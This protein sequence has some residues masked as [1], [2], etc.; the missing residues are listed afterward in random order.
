MKAKVNLKDFLEQNISQGNL[1]EIFVQLKKYF[2]EKEEGTYEDILVL[3]SEYNQMLKNEL[4]YK[5]EIPGQPNRLKKGLLYFIS[6]I[7]PKESIFV[8]APAPVQKEVPIPNNVET[9]LAPKNE[10]NLKPWLITLSLLVVTLFSGFGLYN[11]FNKP[12]PEGII[13]PPKQPVKVISVENLFIKND[14]KAKLESENLGIK[15]SF[16]SLFSRSSLIAGISKELHF[17]ITCQHPKDY[18]FDKLYAEIWIDN[19]LVHKEKLLNSI[20]PSLVKSETKVSK[21]YVKIEKSVKI[22]QMII[23]DDSDKIV[24]NLHQI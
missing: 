11:Y 22:A 10:T 24:F 18:S 17:V 12:K 20:K 7:P 2:K 5:T 23:L 15:I 1:E 3:E 13:I 8:E 19:Q 4:I 21:F 9:I 14:W 16:D 6:Q